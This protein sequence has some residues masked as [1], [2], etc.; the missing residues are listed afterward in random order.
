MVLVL[1]V[2]V[3]V[4]V[5]YHSIGNIRRFYAQNE[6]RRGL[7]ARFLTRGF[8]IKPSVQKL[9]REKANMQMSMYVLRPVLAAFEY[10]ACRYLN[11][12]N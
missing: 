12:E 4:S 6:V 7:F 11:A 2:C 5:F 1:C 10:C 9:W 3:C 8:S